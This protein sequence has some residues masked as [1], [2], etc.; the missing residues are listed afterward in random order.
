MLRGDTVHYLNWED[1]IRA[2]DY[3]I[4][5]EREFSYKN[6]NNVEKV[7]HIC[8]FVSGLWQIHPFCE[9][10]TR[11]TAVFTIQYLR[12]MGYDVTND[13]FKDHSWYF[14]NALVRA[15]YK[16]VRLGIDYDISFLERFF[17]NLLLD[18]QNELKNRSMLINSPD[19]WNE[20]DD[21]PTIN[22]AQPMITDDNFGIP[23][24]KGQLQ[25][26]G[27]VGFAWTQTHPDQSISIPIVA[28]REDSG[29]R[30]E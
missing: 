28:R 17:R 8:R 6:C 10:N 18:E 25:D 11:T 5:Q 4:Q 7:S 24:R 2:I 20:T 26:G 3:D 19:G 1:L 21:K 23:Q 30:G 15:N 16:N 9:G 12:S 14:R 29:A 13:L 22:D 27:I